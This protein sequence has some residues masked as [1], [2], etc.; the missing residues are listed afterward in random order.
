MEYKNNYSYEEVQK[1]LLDCENSFNKKID[2]KDEIISQ[3]AENIMAIGEEVSMYR[4]K[5]NAISAALISAVEKAQEIELTSKKLYQA[6]IS[7]VRLLYMRL[8][9][10]INELSIKYPEIKSQYAYNEIY[11]KYKAIT[12]NNNI[13][14]S[15]R[16]SQY[17]QDFINKPNY[18]EDPFKTLLTK[19]T[20]IFDKKKSTE[21]V[22]I[23]RADKHI[24]E[25]SSGFNL[26]EALNPSE[27]LGDIMKSF[28]LENKKVK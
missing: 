14:T 21:P 28:N 10:C 3:Q 26:K 5:D 12:T 20:D 13:S 8:E 16:S 1:M 2:E 18:T 6:E 11:E 4:K 24:Y 7:R 19:I 27:S 25:S 15:M 17:L 22:Y 9:K 23:Q